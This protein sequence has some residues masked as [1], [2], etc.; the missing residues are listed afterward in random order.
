MFEIDDADNAL[1]GGHITDAPVIT[2]PWMAFQRILARQG[3][4]VFMDMRFKT[5]VS[6]AFT[7]SKPL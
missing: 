5:C 7:I 3:Y 2:G 6:P 4:D 1:R